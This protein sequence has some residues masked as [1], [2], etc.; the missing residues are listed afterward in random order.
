L[1]RLYWQGLLENSPKFYPALFFMLIT[2]QTAYYIP[3][4]AQPEHGIL[5]GI[6]ASLTKRRIAAEKPATVRQ[7]AQYFLN[8]PDSE[9]FRPI[10]SRGFDS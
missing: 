10:K 7:N 3:Y 8:T 1:L 2:A 5:L 6:A 4:G 9:N